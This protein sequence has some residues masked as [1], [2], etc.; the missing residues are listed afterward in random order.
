MATGIIPPTR[1]M[2]TNCQCG[3]DHKPLILARIIVDDSGCWRWSGRLSRDGYGT[4]SHGGTV[5]QAHR[6]SYIAFRGEF[7]E[8]LVADHLCR[9]RYCVNPD[10][11]GAV[12]D[13][14]NILRSECIA[15]RNARKDVCQNGHDDWMVNPRGRT[16]RACARESAALKLRE[17]RIS[18]APADPRHGT[19]NGYTNLGCRCERCCKANTDAH[20]EYMSRRRA[21]K[22]QQH[23]EVA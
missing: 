20:R 17:K 3:A 5:W 6:L 11:L 16:C 18:D 1:R 10:H 21:A 15:A 2:R 19:T 8:G 23:G 4:F 12:T 22:R 13:R 9:N 7:P 14:V